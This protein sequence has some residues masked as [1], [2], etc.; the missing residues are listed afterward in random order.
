MTAAHIC[1]SSIA[2]FVFS[3]RQQSRNKGK[4]EYVVVPDVA[5]VSFSKRAAWSAVEGLILFEKVMI[6]KV[7][8]LGVGIIP[9][10]A[11]HRRRLRVISSLVLARRGAL[12][13]GH[14][15]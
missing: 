3:L 2:I 7:A 15:I 8:R 12:H 5:G 4:V 11:H 1:S 9:A 14:H 13:R 6:V 10:L